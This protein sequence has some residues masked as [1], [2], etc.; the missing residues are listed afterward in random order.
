MSATKI[1][2][3]MDHQHAFVTEFT[4][5]PMKDTKVV[6]EHTD[7]GKNFAKGENHM[8][9]KEQ[10]QQ[11]DYYKKL[12][13][14]IKNYSAVVLFGPTSAKDE[15][16]NK[17]STDHNFSAIKIEIKDADK[18]TDNQRHAFVRKYFMQHPG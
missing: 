16:F 5:D 3:W 2:I 11:L 4:I 18:M 13:G 12:S 6:N 14:I 10:H 17:I 15:L 9:T 1:G 8:H 7:E